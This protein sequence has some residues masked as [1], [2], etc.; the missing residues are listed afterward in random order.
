MRPSPVSPQAWKPLPTPRMV[1]PSAASCAMLRCVAGCAHISRFMAGAISRGTRSIGRARHIRLRSSSERPC[2]S[3]AMKSALHGAMRMASACR[4]RLMCGMLL[5]RARP[6]ASVDGA[7][8]SACMV[9]GV[10][11]CSAA[12]VITTCTVAPS[13]ISSRHSS[14][15]L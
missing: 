14:A 8:D 10:M 3:R 7:F 4:D 2:T 6:T 13:L 1:A 5:A 15:D 11:N 9:T 12:S